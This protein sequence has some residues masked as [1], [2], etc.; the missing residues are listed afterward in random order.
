MFNSTSIEQEGPVV[1]VK[2]ERACFFSRKEQAGKFVTSNT[3]ES[4]NSRKFSS[5]DSR[6]SMPRNGMKIIETIDTKDIDYIC[7]EPLIILT[8]DIH[9]D[10]L[11]SFS[12]N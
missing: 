9:I 3:K 8:H 6:R 10:V 5:S 12:F 11:G 2:K 7:P 1:Q 4:S